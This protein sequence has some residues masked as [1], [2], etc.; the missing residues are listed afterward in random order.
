MYIII[1]EWVIVHYL[2]SSTFAFINMTPWMLL[3]N[4]HKHIKVF[5]SGTLGAIWPRFP[6]LSFPMYSF[7]FTISGDSASDQMFGE[8]TNGWML[9]F[10]PLKI[11]ETGFQERHPSKAFDFLAMCIFVPKNHLDGLVPLLYIVYII[12]QQHH[13]FF[14]L[15]WPSFPSVTCLWLPSVACLLLA[16]SKEE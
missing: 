12:T 4:L 2:Y 14:Y 6:P 5:C 3:H 8:E 9:P 10:E 16:R 1:I 15:S 7:W 13:F 11:F